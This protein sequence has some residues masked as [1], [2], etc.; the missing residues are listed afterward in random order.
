LT[1]CTQPASGPEQGGL[2]TFLRPHLERIALLDAIKRAGLAEVEVNDGGG[3]WQRRDPN[4]L[5]EAVRGWNGV[6][7]IFPGDG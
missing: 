2:D 3:S 4:Q 1:G 6:D 7:L 5:A